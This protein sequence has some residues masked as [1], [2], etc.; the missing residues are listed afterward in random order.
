MD[1]KQNYHKGWQNR[2]NRA[3]LPFQFRTVTGSNGHTPPKPP[4][5]LIRDY[6]RH[7]TLAIHLRFSMASSI[8]ET[9]H[10]RPYGKRRPRMRRQKDLQRE[11]S[12]FM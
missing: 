8:R 1:Y 6:V 10:S 4:G 2:P 9:L 5:A 3:T 7:L 12:S 11:A